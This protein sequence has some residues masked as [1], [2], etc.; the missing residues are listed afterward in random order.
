MSCIHMN[1]IFLF[2]PLS[3]APTV[4][5]NVWS[6]ST[7]K[8]D[9]TPIHLAKTAI[10]KQSFLWK[11]LKNFR[12][13]HCPSHIFLKRVMQKHKILLHALDIAEKGRTERCCFRLWCPLTW[14]W[15]MQTYT[16]VSKKQKKPQLN[17]WKDCKTSFALFPAMLTIFFFAKKVNTSVQIFLLW[18]KFYRG[19]HIISHATKQY[20]R[21]RELLSA[22]KWSFHT[23]PQKEK[24][25]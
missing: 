19:T 16:S 20:E 10:G 2:S 6:P 1:K 17:C 12:P 4:G 18:G 9:R 23:W 15:E 7:E 11:S 5:H 14:P 22:R 13:Y 21:W 24:K 8:C 3:K 25:K